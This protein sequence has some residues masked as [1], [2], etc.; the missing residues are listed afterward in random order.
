MEELLIQLEKLGFSKDYLKTVKEQELS[1]VVVPSVDDV[2]YSIYD[3]QI[4]YNSQL[5][6]SESNKIIG[7]GSLT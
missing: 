5:L 2:E 4:S 3:N 1:E 7:D 6:Y